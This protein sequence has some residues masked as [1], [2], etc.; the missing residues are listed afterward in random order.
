MLSHSAFPSQAKQVKTGKERPS[1]LPYKK[2]IASSQAYQIWY[3]YSW[4]IEKNYLH[5]LKWVY[6]SKWEQLSMELW[7]GYQGI[8]G[9]RT[10]LF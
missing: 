3:P 7:L 4:T 2:K 8:G 9:G 1:N 5:K 10:F 6:L